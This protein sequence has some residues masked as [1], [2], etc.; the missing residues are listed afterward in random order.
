MNNQKSK[1]ENILGQVTDCSAY[2]EKVVLHF[3][4]EKTAEEIFHTI[5][6]IIRDNNRKIYE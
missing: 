1:E 4:T 2:G 6:R 5:Y 3:D